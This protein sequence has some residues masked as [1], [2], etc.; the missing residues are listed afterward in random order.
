MSDKII[1]CD[2]DH[3][4]VDA[5]AEVFKKAGVSFSWH[6]CVKQEDVIRDCNGAT[7]YLNQYA[8]MDKNI[9]KAVP[10]LKCVVR[11]GVGVD[12]VN[13]KDADEYG[14]QVCNVPDYGTCE[15]AD[16]ALA[17]MMGLV[18]KVTL[19]NNDIR[20]GI[21]NYAETI[22]VHRLAVSTVGIIGLGRIGSQFAKRVKALG[23][24]VI[25]YDVAFGESDRTFPDFVEQVSLEEV[26][27][28]SDII[29]IH[30]SLNE[31]TMNLIGKK[32]FAMMKPSAYIINVARGGIIN[33]DALLDALE[34]KKIAGAGIDVVKAEHLDKDSPL[35]K[36]KNL[37]VSPHMAWYSEEAALDLKR[38]AAEEAVRFVKGEKVHYP[39]NKI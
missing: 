33:E 8:H 19:V 22:P 27:K 28:Q 20:N 23:C 6:H 26:L 16:Q 1:I 24:R 39:I 2:C 12:N 11:Y 29:S 34:N 10:T 38:K 14:V 37:I 5:E 30:S 9:F 25:A 18:R 4:N 36:Y 3:D 13:L 7:V 35:L 17:L 15:V 31:Q 21:W 32:E